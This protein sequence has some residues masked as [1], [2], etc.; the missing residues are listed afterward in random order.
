MPRSCVFEL[1][2]SFADAS[3][4]H[5]EMEQVPCPWSD[6]PLGPGLF[7]RWGHKRL[8]SGHGQELAAGLGQHVR[9]VILQ[10][11]TVASSPFVL[12]STAMGRGRVLEWSSHG[13]GG[14]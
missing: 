10:P 7:S 3:W 2:T 4:A 5:P 14:Y 8:V 12:R 9:P 11:F 1:F 13:S 6:H